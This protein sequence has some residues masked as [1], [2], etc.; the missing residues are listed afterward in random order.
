MIELLPHQV[1]PVLDTR[2]KVLIKS[3]CGSGKTIIAIQKLINLGLP[4]LVITTKNDVNKWKRCG[5]TYNLDI[6]VYSKDQQKK[7]LPKEK[8]YPVI[9]LDESHRIQSSGKPS[10]TY[11]SLL[12]YIQRVNPDYVWMMSA[13]PFT[14]SYWCFYSYMQ[15]LGLP[16]DYNQF[17]DKYFT[18][19][20]VNEKR[21]LKPGEKK[22]P[23][24]TDFII[25]KNNEKEDPREEIK[26]FLIDIDIKTGIEHDI[27]HRVPINVTLMESY[28]SIHD[29]A[30]HE[31]SHK[32]MYEKLDELVEAGTIIACYYRDEVPKLKSKY[33]ALVID[34]DNPALIEHQDVDKY[35]VIVCQMDTMNAYEL[36]HH[37][38]II[39][40][41]RSWTYS[42]YEQSRGR[43]SR[44][45]NFKDNYY[46]FLI[47]YY[48]NGEM[49]T[50]SEQVH[51][52]LL[53]KK[54]FQDY[55]YKRMG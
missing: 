8:R 53:L 20:D 28:G 46:H 21:F 15:Y 43:I 12:S 16:V 3:G 4:A 30:K 44:I 6:E 37:K 48:E 9:I 34:S 5:K 11:K 51:K 10:T 23:K 31:N 13:T 7:Y 27:I 49:R 25:T 54:D 19:F 22:Y 18:R 1:K 39:Y 42:N 26:D 35:P 33:K 29:I 52:N 55:D 47:P 32:N 50:V 17:R 45:N 36:P 40:F 38:N 41:S 14:A 24:K 2:K